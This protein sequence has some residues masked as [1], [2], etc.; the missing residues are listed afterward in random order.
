MRTAVWEIDAKKI[1]EGSL[2]GQQLCVK[3]QHL[4]FSLSARCLII[5]L[6]HTE[7]NSV[8]RQA[9]HKP[10]CCGESNVPFCLEL[11]VW[12]R[13]GKK[14]NA[15]KCQPNC[16]LDYAGFRHRKGEKERTS[17]RRV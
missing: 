15:G 8:M 17:V 3:Q 7:H 2:K 5:I 12:E 11:A 10:L 16:V 6:I 14:K 1:N 4:L 9:L 13:G